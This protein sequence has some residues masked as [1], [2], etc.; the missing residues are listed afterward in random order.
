MD[1]IFVNPKIKNI[2]KYYKRIWS[3]KHAQS[4]LGWD[5]KVNIPV[6]GIK[7]R[8]V[9]EGELS[10][11]SREL[12]TSSRFVELIEKASKEYLND[13]EKGVVRVLKRDI[14]IAKSLPPRFI[15][16]KSRIESRCV[17]IWE[18]AKR[19]DN[20][21]KFKPW[22][23]R[24][25]E[26]ERKTAEYLGYDRYPYDALLDFYEEGLRMKDLDPLFRDLKKGLK[27]IL[28]KLEKRALEIH[29]IEKEKYEIENMKKVNLLI[30]KIFGFPLEKRGKIHISEHPFTES[31]SINDVRITTNYEG[32]DFKRSLLSTIHEFGHAL[33]ELQVNKRFDFTPIGKGVSSGIHESQSRFWENIIGRSKEF[34]QL[35]H[36]ILKQNLKFLSNYSFG[37]IFDY[38]NTVKP[39]LIRTEADEVTYNFHIILRYELE[40]LIINEKIDVDEL[41]K[42]WNEE[43][44]NLLG[45]KPN[46][47]KEGIL[48][49]IHWSSGI[50]GY[51]PT[52]TL[53]TVLSAQLK[54]HIL[55][56][57]R[58]FNQKIINR[59]F[60]SIKEWLREKIHKFGSMYSPK[61]LLKKSFGETIRVEYFLDYLKQK[62]IK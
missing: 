17:K 59:D 60:S 55:R 41:P 57:V 36:P 58:D 28:L 6:L 40:K 8:S 16:E 34:I 30:L 56:D 11:L 61:D 47:Y 52:Y 1:K 13:Y 48:Q 24:I 10:F 12:L 35:I 15:R 18:E 50:I 20:F 9:A 26:I 4:L 22:L 53:G 45:V 43:M 54:K 25:V 33:Y 29:P 21:L 42:I 37:D 31:I 2:L 49:D 7:E 62:Y 19:K 14:K 32:I 39:S 46:N 38:F 51:F 23:K 44:E 3:V 5:T 27:R